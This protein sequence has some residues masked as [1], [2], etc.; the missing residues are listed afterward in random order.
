MNI[1]IP[2]YVTE[3]LKRLHD[4]GYEAYVVGGCVRDSILGLSPDDWD[5]CTEAEPDEMKNCF[6]G[7]RSVDTGIQH[8][9]VTAISKGKPVEVTTYR[10]DGTYSDG[11]HPD[12]VTFTRS[13][14][15]DL[16]RR[17][18]TINAMAYDPEN[19]LIDPFSG[20]EDLKRHLIRCVGEP[21]KRFSEDALRILRAFRFSSKLGFE[22]EEKTAR[23]AC[24]MAE[25]VRKVARERVGVEFTKLVMGTGVSKVLPEYRTELQKCGIFPMAEDA[26]LRKIAN[27]PGNLPERLSVLFPENLRKTLRDLRLDHRTIEGCEQIQKALQEPVSSENAVLRFQMMRYGS[28]SVRAM[29]DIRKVYP[30]DGKTAQDAVSAEHEL[31]RI[32]DSGQVWNLKQLA[33]SGR[34]LIDA[35]IPQGKQIGTVLQKLLLMVIEGKLENQKDILKDTAHVLFCRENL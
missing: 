30:G 32:L 7:L 26:V 29:L 12:D 3:V 20:R 24:E 27:L 15:E 1:N 21:E 10:I 11:R 6:I 9:T 17:D 23:A 28:S 33:V 14:R 2:E 13:L 16:A 35:G 18:F 31:E 5:V 19:G 25:T 8:G 34:D 4:G 22:I